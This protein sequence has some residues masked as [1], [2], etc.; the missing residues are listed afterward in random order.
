ME[1]KEKRIRVKIPMP[2]I[3][4]KRFI[5]RTIKDDD[6]FLLALENPMG[7]MKECSVKLDTSAFIPSDF[8]TLFGVLSGLREMIKKKNI[9]DL[10]FERIFG[11][12]AEIHG[13]SLRMEISQGF[14]KEW[15]NRDAL[16]QK[17][18]CFSALQN[19]EADRERSATSAKELCQSQEVRIEME[20]V[21]VTTT[22]SE[23]FRNQNREWDN[24]DAVQTRRSETGTTK[25]F[26]KDGQRSLE[27]LLSGP[28]IHP[29]DLATISATCA[30]KFLPGKIVGNPFWICS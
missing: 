10:G 7:A 23:T 12:A 2:S 4:L 27:D 13:A 28:L 1:E 22:S 11:Y 6:F 20:F 15:D 24:A 14:F 26:Q 16:A 30:A 18:K 21:G 19:F 17:G 25:G 9:K 5:E 8:A 29:Q 3:A